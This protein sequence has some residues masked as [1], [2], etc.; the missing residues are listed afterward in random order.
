MASHFESFLLVDAAA[1]QPGRRSGS[2]AGRDAS[3]A[4]H[5]SKGV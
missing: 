3:F 4:V 1:S 5:L 2:G